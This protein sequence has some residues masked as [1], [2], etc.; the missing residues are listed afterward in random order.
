MKGADT[1]TGSL[2]NST[3]LDDSLESYVSTS[4]FSSSIPGTYTITYDITMKAGKSNVT[5]VGTKSITIT[6]IAPKELIGVKIKNV[7]AAPKYNTQNKLTGYDATGQIYAIYD[8]GEEK[9]YDTID[10]N[11]SPNQSK[12]NIDVTVYG[13]TFTVHVVNP[14]YLG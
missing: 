3:I 14:S 13:Q 5:F 1:W 11:F 9:L 12:R 2:K 7:S 4:T 8:N 10:F 6:V